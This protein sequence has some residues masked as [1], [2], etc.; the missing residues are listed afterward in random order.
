MMTH[1]QVRKVVD[2]A[3]KKRIQG[4]VDRKDVVIN[5]IE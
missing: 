5:K 3:G 2:W 4:D 1:N